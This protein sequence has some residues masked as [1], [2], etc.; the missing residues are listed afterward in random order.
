MSSPDSTKTP[1]EDEDMKHPES[2]SE[3]TVSNEVEVV[4]PSYQPSR[5]E[6]NEDMRVDA[7][8]EESIQ[9]L[10]RPV[11]NRYIKRPKRRSSDR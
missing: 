9:A 8:F 1:S 10:V 3:Q 4:H 5:A 7:T 2:K 11:R 6:L